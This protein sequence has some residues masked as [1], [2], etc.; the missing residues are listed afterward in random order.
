[1]FFCF[2][3]FNQLINLSPFSSPCSRDFSSLSKDNVYQNN[4]LVSRFPS[5]AFTRDTQKTSGWSVLIIS[6]LPSFSVYLSR[7]AGIWD[8]RDEAGH[9][10]AVGPKW[11]GFHQSARLFECHHLPFVALPLLQQEVLWCVEQS[12]SS[13]FWSSLSDAFIHCYLQQSQVCC[14]AQRLFIKGHDYWRSLAG[15]KDYIRGVLSSLQ[16]I[17]NQVLRI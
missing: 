1:M 16:D 10:C 8:C 11:H 7:S 3:S 2:L 6:E 14:L 12:L 13:L 5:C 4:K 15:S 17:Q 9:P